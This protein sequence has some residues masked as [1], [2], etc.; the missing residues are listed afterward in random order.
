MT[1]LG[2]VLCPGG[3]ENSRFKRRRRA[4]EKLAV[5]MTILAIIIAFFGSI[6][7]VLLAVVWFLNDSGFK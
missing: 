2:R 5:G 6:L 3:G 1:I 4:I 7:F